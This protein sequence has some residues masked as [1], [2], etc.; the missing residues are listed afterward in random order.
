MRVPISDV[1]ELKREI[2]VVLA[3]RSLADEYDV[4]VRGKIVAVVPREPPG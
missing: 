4:D 1:P 3:E 2:R